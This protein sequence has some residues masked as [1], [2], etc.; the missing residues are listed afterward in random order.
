MRLPGEWEN[1]LKDTID[2]AAFYS[3]LQLFVTNHS[4]VLPVKDKIFAVFDYMGPLDVQC[5]LFGED[6]YPR[7][8]SACGVAF[9]DKEINNWQDKTHGN[10][11]KNILKAIVV[12]RGKASYSTKID[13]IRIIAERINFKSPPQLFEHWLKQGVLLINT[14]LTFTNPALKKEHFEFWQPFHIKLIRALNQRGKSP[15]FILWGGKAAKWEGL[16]AE[17]IDDPVKII[18]QGHPTFIHQFMD[19]NRPHFSPFTEIIEKT[20]LSWY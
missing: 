9:W 15:F 16:I 6:P 18:K 2:F 8:K 12:A 17:F 3:Q 14:A 4:P 1:F 7:V 13:E 19:K 5:V 11:L 10:S 20:G